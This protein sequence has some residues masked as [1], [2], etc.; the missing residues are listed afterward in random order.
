VA[1]L[2]IGYLA[3]VALAPALHHDLEC[4]VQHPGHCDA[5][6]ALLAAPEAADRASSGAQG[7]VAAAAVAPQDDSPARGFDRGAQ[8]DRAPPSGA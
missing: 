4:H 3:I 5:C 1:L 6:R 8:S 7:P 2:A